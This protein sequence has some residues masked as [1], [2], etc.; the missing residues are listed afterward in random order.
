MN[1]LGTEIHLHARVFRTGHDWYA[2]LDDWN[3]PQ[4]DDPYWYGY[5]TTQRAAIDAACARLAAYHL[6]QAHRIS[7]QLLTPATTSA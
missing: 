3:D 7:H 1:D 2:D 4:P 6:S 5:Y